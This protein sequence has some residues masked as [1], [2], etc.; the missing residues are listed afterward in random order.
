MRISAPV[1]RLN[2]KSKA[3]QIARLGSQGAVVGMTS[4]DFPRCPRRPARLRHQSTSPCARHT[5]AGCARRSPTRID[6]SRGYIDPPFPQIRI[7]INLRHERYPTCS[8][9]VD[10]VERPVSEDR[11]CCA[12][13][14]TR[15]RCMRGHR[16]GEILVRLRT[17]SSSRQASAL[18][19]WMRIAAGSFHEATS[20]HPLKRDKS[21]VQ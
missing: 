20:C 17:T 15:R 14:A 16:R 5:I 12:R 2:E 13:Q 3:E 18:S 19:A 11:T 9:G 10:T 7:F 1:R 21:S 6:G 8:P 4:S